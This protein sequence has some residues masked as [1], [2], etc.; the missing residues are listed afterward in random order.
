MSDYRGHIAAG[1]L[2]Y[3]ATLA[4]V[5]GLPAMLGRSGDAPVVDWWEVPAQLAVAMLAG[6]WPDVDVTSHGR[7]LFYRLFLIFDLYLIISGAWQAAALLGLFA[8]LPGLGRHR[9]W[10]HKVWA[11]LLVPLSIPAAAAFL[12]RDGSFGVAPDMGRV[13][14]VLPYYLAAVVGYFSHLAADGFLG[15]GVGRAMAVVLWP[16]QVVWRKAAGSRRAK[17]H[18]HDKK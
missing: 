4:V 7:K 18:E 5:F 16:I 17:R 14:A 9:G 11:A 13:E 1:A 15:R 6:L 8:I 3:S 12:Q 2:F 10:T